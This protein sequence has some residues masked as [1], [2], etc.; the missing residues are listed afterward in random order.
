VRA[1]QVTLVLSISVALAS[2]AQ[3]LAA[4]QQPSE[5]LL[6]LP[7]QASS[8]DSAASIALSDAVRDR[9]NGLVKNKVM[10]VT[11]AK[12]CEALAQSGFPCNGLLDDQQARQLARFLQVHAYVTGSL[13]K[14]GSTLTAIVEMFDI[15]S[16]G[17]AGRFTATN[18]NPGTTAALAETIA[19]HI[20]TTVRIS[21]PIRNCNDER[22]KGQFGRARSEAQKALAI[23][24]NSTGAYL[25]IA[26]IFEARRDPVDSVIAAARL[27]LKGDSC[28]GT[29]WEKIA[30]GYQQK[31]DTVQA[32][33]AYI[34]Q[35]CGEPRNTQ[36]RLGVA[37]LLRQMKRHERAVQVL[38][39]G[40]KY[41]PG[42]PQ[43]LDMK[44]TICTESSNFRCASD[45]WV[46]KFIHDTASGG[47][48]TFLKP[49][50]GAAQQV[51]DTQAL[52]KFTAA[53][54]KHFPNNVSYI[55]ARAGALELAGRMDSAMVYYKKAL[56]LE[57]ND[58]PISLQ[59]G[60]AI[61]D[62]AVW[63]TAAANR[64]KGDTAAL[65]KLRVP[66]I[67]KVDSAKPY[68]RPGLGSP[69]S[70]QRLAANVI[71]LTAGSKLA[72]AGAYGAGYTWLD[73]LL[74]LIAPKNAADTLG[75]KQQV[76]IN[77]SFWYGLSS[78]LTLS[79][80]YQLMTKAKGASRCPDARAVFDRLA[81]TKAALLLGRRVHPPTADQMLNFVG[82]Y[83]KAKPSVQAAFKCR[84]ALN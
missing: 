68:L 21:E 52:D 63:D 81:R 62:A 44:L 47:D 20:A 4:P 76:R 59:I 67:Q 84:P 16:S 12:L 75:P 3:Q 2:P 78:V 28:N 54:Y 7:F 23:D 53:A 79:G 58:V 51:S 70:T 69:D 45:V 30:S 66:F 26:T 82:Q 64:V 74:T 72:Q 18:G 56:A 60:K 34:T 65:N 33:E 37:Q 57:P 35:L 27:A 24:P 73:S 40:L 6:I 55:R 61:V 49:A 11:K 32:A 1:L 8:A 80:P 31:G 19:Q 50:I 5:R 48:T 22:R 39:E 41:Q 71:M 77:A 17:I 43:L 25:C 83:E 42:E 15:G 10:V 38:D 29:A 36:K 14:K 46:A 13:E 9:V